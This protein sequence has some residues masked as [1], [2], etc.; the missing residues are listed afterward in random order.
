MFRE[1]SNSKLVDQ[2][3]SQ[4]SRQE[5]ELNPE[6]DSVFI[7]RDRNISSDSIADTDNSQIISTELLKINS[8]SMTR[9]IDER[10]PGETSV[11][12]NQFVGTI[13]CFT[14]VFNLDDST[15]I[16]HIWKFKE[17]II[18]EIEIPIGVSIRWRCWSK[19]NIKPE[20]VGD[21]EVVIVNDEGQ[22]LDSV[23]F[24]IVRET[25]SEF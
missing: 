5:N 22:E 6:T 20:W 9:E 15:T 16:S 3:F 17:Q 13:N 19:L 25:F 24:Q 2:N 21:W 11:R 18:S 8:I 12:F 7:Q 1:S 14:S 4:N 10:T 23:H